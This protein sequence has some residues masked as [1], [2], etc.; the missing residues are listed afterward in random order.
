MHP[1]GEP[2]DVTDNMEIDHLFILRPTCEEVYYIANNT[3]VQ[4][5]LVCELLDQQMWL[6]SAE[7]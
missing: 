5:K 2:V 6:K 3:A 4:A 1:W 7:G